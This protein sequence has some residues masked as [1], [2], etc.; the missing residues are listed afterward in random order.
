MQSR[1]N[2]LFPSLLALFF[3]PLIAAEVEVADLRI[4]VGILSRDFKGESTATT[5]QSGGNIT[6][7]SQV[8]DGRDSEL[9]WRGQVQYVAG[10]LGSFGG[11]IYGAGI[12]VN[13]ASWDNKFQTAHVTT[14]TV[15]VLLGYGYGITPNWHVELTPFA[16]YGQSYYSVSAEGS[17]E[18]HRGWDN[19]V[20]VGAKI[21]TYV[22][23][24]KHVLIGLE[25]PYLMGQFD[26]DY[27]Y[28]D[29]QNRS[30]T[31]T[32]KRSNQ[33]FGALA[34]LGYRF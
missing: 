24:D 26:P 34:S 32:D 3:S 13:Q 17:S 27:S 4:S 30:I 6:T 5:T 25:I 20:E 1:S 18:T 31:V 16:G 12:A 22:A 2:F 29:D 21:A 28:H 14:P 8:V 11:F 7:T 33:G 15:N 23:L 19:Y 10:S 9:N